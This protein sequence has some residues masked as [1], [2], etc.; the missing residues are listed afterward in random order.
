MLVALIAT[1]VLS[2]VSAITRGDVESARATKNVTPPDARTTVRRLAIIEDEPEF[3]TEFYRLLAQFH[4]APLLR[5][6][7]CLP[8]SDGA[9]LIFESDGSATLRGDRGATIHCAKRHF[10]WGVTCRGDWVR[11]QDRSIEGLTT[12]VIRSDDVLVVIDL[13]RQTAGFLEI[14]S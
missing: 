12:L 4:V 7:N 1:V 11:L 13:A 6:G 2:G 5:L 10:A 14:G 8:I 3:F 9:Q